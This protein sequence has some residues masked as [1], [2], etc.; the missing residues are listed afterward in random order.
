MERRYKIIFRVGLSIKVR[1]ISVIFANL[2]KLVRNKVK[3][4]ERAQWSNG[5]TD[6]LYIHG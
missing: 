4:F 5:K 3:S 6:G 1:H 2:R